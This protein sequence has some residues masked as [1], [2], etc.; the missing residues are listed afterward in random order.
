MNTTRPWAKAAA[1]VGA[2]VVGAVV[3]VQPRV[4]GQLA[5]EL[6]D[7]FLAAL[8]SFLVG[9]TVLSACLLVWAPGRRGFARVVA[10]VREH[11]TSPWFL[12]G[13]LAGAFAV[14]TQ[15]LTAASLGVALFTV[16]IVGGQS[17]GSLLLDRRGIGTMPPRPLT[18]PRVA[19]SLLAIVA[20]CWA[21]SDRLQGDVSWGLLVLPVLA[22]V[23]TGW[24]QAVNGQVREHAGSV[25]TASIVS[26]TGGAI[27]LAIATTVHIALAGPPQPFPTDPW[28]YTGGLLGIVF[29]AGSAALVRATGVLLFGL[30]SIAGQLVM[31]I[32]LDVVAPVA[33]AVVAPA[34]IGGAVLAA[35][36]VGVASIRPRQRAQA[37]A[38]GV[39][40]PEA[41]AAEPDAR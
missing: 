34:T 13:G 19:G 10:A 30:A 24:Q 38:G 5:V 21:V 37:A 18:V 25:L 40:E 17:V 2:A 28:L 22:G 6:D 8:I 35:L 16:A 1:V 4:N 23:A 11:R 20:V 14:L 29:I 7:G 32:V 9:V 41:P 39:P 15:G 27:A 12:L 3:A 26:F 33:G 31:A 36:A